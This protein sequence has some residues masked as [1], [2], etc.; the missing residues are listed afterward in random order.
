MNLSISSF[1]QDISAWCVEQ[2]TQ[3]PPRFDDDAG[4][5]GINGR[6]QIG[7]TP[8]KQALSASY[9]ADSERNLMQ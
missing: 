3:K 7:G 2:I 9:P 4:F 8:V 6:N 1:N 5:E